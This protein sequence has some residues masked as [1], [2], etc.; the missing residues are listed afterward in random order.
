MKAT[1]FLYAERVMQWVDPQWWIW[2][3]LCIF[4]LCMIHL[5]PLQL[6]PENHDF[7]D[8]VFL[9]MRLV[10][11]GSLVLLLIFPFLFYLTF[12]ALTPSARQVEASRVVLAWY[13]EMA[14]DYWGLPV[15]AWILGVT[16]NFSWHRY[17]SPW[18]SQ[19]RR[20]FRVNQ[21]E[22]KE[23][24]IRKEHHVY[25]T[26]RFKPEQ[27]FK[28]GYYFVGLDSADRPIYIADEIFESTHSGTFAPTGFGKGVSHGVI[29]TQSIRKGNATFWIDPKDDKRAPYIL[30]QEAK[31]AGRP[32]IYLDLN[33]GGKG[34][35][36]PFK[37]GALRDRRA[38]MLAAFNL[39]PS[40]TNADVYKAKERR[41]VD[42]LLNNTDGS[43]AAMYEEAKRGIKDDLSQLRD[44]LA[45]WAQISTFTPNRKRKG[46][47]IEQ[48]LLNDAVVYIKGSL[49]DNV[50]KAATRAYVS[51]LI[52]E[53]GRLYPQRTSQITAFIDEVRFLISEELVDALATTREL[54]MNM[55]LATQA[56]S[57]LKNIEDKT[58][59]G[60]ALQTSVEVN[61]QI[62][63]IYRAGDPKTAEWGEKLSGTKTIRVAGNEKTQINRWGA[64]EWDNVRAFNE[65]EVPFFHRNVFLTFPPMVYL[66]YQPTALPTVGFSSWVD[67]DQS[68]CS[69]ASKD[70]E[71]AN[72][73]TE[74]SESEVA[75]PLAD[76]PIEP[77]KPAVSASVPKA[78]GAAPKVTS[79]AKTSSPVAKATNGAQGAQGAPA[80][81]AR[82]NPKFVTAP[83]PAAAALGPAPARTL[84]ASH[85]A[86]AEPAQEPI[87]DPTLITSPEALPVMELAREGASLEPGADSAA[88]LVDP[89]VLSGES[90]PGVDSEE[91]NSN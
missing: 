54:K 89:P 66:L 4:I 83:G 42:N 84:P 35:W 44:G 45:E 70:S 61:C 52:K 86:A 14:G 34:N 82:S 88:V 64:E 29:L 9:F 26:K 37:S 68:V 67:V 19:F 87:Q 22:D 76:S 21:A 28:D 81:K 85:V 43:I 6:K 63:M 23:S 5:L 72:E 39:K 65:K 59:D 78:V 75:K 80:K 30:Q 74:Q 50:V 51:E 27:Y 48:C 36:H 7:S 16:T 57:D 49:N 58:I 33:P 73:S 38:R 71:E 47:S 46:H 41:E 55:L 17:A 40:G 11:I 8:R 24:D 25:Q 3:S 90:V 62:K 79:A 53:A 15:A 69:W 13:R 12:G 32:F 20:K 31:R 1:A 56:I 18:L 60:E 2:L 91:K 77:A 10:F